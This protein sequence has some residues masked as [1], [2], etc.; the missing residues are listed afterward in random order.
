[1]HALF[2]GVECILIAFGHIETSGTS[3]D[4]KIHFEENPKGWKGTSPAVA[5]FVIPSRV[6][7][8]FGSMRDF[9]VCLRVQRTLASKE[10]ISGRNACLD[11]DF[12]VHK[13][14]L[15]DTRQVFLIPE[16]PL[17]TV[18]SAASSSQNSKNV[19]QGQIGSVTLCGVALDD[20]GEAIVD[21]CCRLNVDN[22][23][24]KKSYQNKAPLQFAQM[25]PC[26]IRISMQEFFQDVIFPFP[27]AGEK[28]R[29]RI[30]RASLYI[31]VGLLLP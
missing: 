4:P 21:F 13:A 25:S 6:I 18:Q 27:V 2:E 10:F 20:G 23:E 9:E 16:Q 31:E 14:R 12:N 22:P 3:G 11:M 19:Q 1:V 7:A 15:M 17:A 30:A 24:V 5:S 28:A 8:N 26:A 29:L